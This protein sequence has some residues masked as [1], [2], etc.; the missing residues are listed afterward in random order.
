M[1]PGINTHAWM[2]G[3]NKIKKGNSFL[4]QTMFLLLLR[5][6]NL[7]NSRSSKHRDKRRNQLRGRSSDNH[8]NARDTS[9]KPTPRNSPDANRTEARPPIA[10]LQLA[11]EQIHEQRRNQSRKSTTFGRPPARS[12]KGQPNP[13]PSLRKPT[14]PQKQNPPEFRPA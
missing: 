14:D 1:R 3:R 7:V 5:T 11:P 12:P 9:Q 4:M 10:S 8:T 6:Y 2:D 13:P